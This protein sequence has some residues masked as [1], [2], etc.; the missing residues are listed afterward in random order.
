MTKD[1]QHTA[2]NVWV[3]SLTLDDIISVLLS[4]YLWLF[5]S[6]FLV[7]ILTDFVFVSYS[8]VRATSKHF[9]NGITG[10]YLLYNRQQRACGK[11]YMLFQP[12][13]T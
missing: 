5:V 1:T 11:L 6:D 9:V 3:S 8:L 10:M 12:R 2:P 13:L 7:L 4:H